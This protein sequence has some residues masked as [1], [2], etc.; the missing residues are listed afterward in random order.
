MEKLP[1]KRKYIGTNKIP[2]KCLITP[3]ELLLITSEDKG[4]KLKSLKLREP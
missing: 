2:Y 1:K 4:L 3:K